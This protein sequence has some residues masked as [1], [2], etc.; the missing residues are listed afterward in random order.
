MKLVLTPRCTERPVQPRRKRRWLP[1]ICWHPST[2]SRYACPL[3]YRRCQWHASP[4][5]RWTAGLGEDCEVRTADG[6]TALLADTPPTAER[7]TAI[8]KLAQN[9]GLTAYDAAYVELTIRSGSDLATFDRK[10]SDAARA[11][12]VAVFGQPQGMAEPW[13]AY[14]RNPEASADTDT[15]RPTTPPYFS[16]LGP[17]S[18]HRLAVLGERRVVLQ[19]GQDVRQRRNR[20]HRN[21]I[22]LGHVLHGRVR[23]QRVVRAGAFHAVHGDQHGR[24]GAG[25][26]DD[27]HRFAHR[28]AG[29]DHVVDD[30]DLALERRAD[31]RAALAMVLGFLAVVG[32]RHVAPLHGRVAG[33]GHGGGGGQRDAPCR[34]GR[35]ACRSPRPSPAAPGHRSRPAC[36]RKRR[37]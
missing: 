37:N 5:T 26:A 15:E 35:T 28:S 6:S 34:R 2:T 13:A 24:L 36:R 29:G 20:H 17:I 12:G 3:A 19:Q 11:C 9:H 22:G 16:V 30:H 18:Q 25:G 14:G 8:H 23:R 7:A 31:Q 1:S 32:E 21:A 27:L 10:L 4:G 33:Q